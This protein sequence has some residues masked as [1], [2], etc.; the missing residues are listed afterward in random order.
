MNNIFSFETDMPACIAAKNSTAV[1]SNEH[2]RDGKASLK[3]CFAPGADI[4]FTTPVPFSPLNMESASKAIDTFIFWLCSENPVSGSLKIEFFKDNQACCWFETALG[5]TG[6]RTGWV[7]YERDMQGT[8]QN[9]MDGFR[10]IANTKNEGVLYLDQIIPVVKIDSRH[11]TPDMQFP[12]VHESVSKEANNHWLSL[13]KFMRQQNAAVS[14]GTQAA[15][16][17]ELDIIRLRLTQ[18]ILRYTNQPDE[19]SLKAVIK[20][21]YSADGKMRRIDVM[22]IKESYPVQQREQL[23]ALTD[24]VE[25]REV[26]KAMLD[27]AYLWHKGESGK[28]AQHEAEFIRLFNHLQYLGFAGGSALGTTHHLGYQTRE[29]MY[30]LMLMRRPMADNGLLQAAADTA[31]WYSGSGRALGSD[32]DI[33]LESLD[34]FNTLSHGMLIGALLQE[35]PSAA[36]IMLKGFQKWLNSCLLPAPGLEGT[37][38]TDNCMFHHCNHYPAYA[39]GGIESISA[40]IYFISVPSYKISQQA[41]ESVKK[42]VLAFRVYCNTLEW[43]IGMSSRHPDGTGTQYSGISSLKAFEYLARAGSPDGTQPVDL[44]LAAACMRL[45][46]YLNKEEKPF[47]IAAEQTPT[48]HWGFNYACASV[49]RRGEWMLTVRG[50]SKYIWG[51]E[52]YLAANLYGRYIAYGQLELLNR[53]NPINHRQSGYS[54]FGFNWNF[55]PGTTAIELPFNLL[56][57][58]V[59]N[60]DTYSGFEEMIISDQAFCGGTSLFS[61]GVFAIKLHEHGKYNGTHR[62]NKSYFFIDGYVVCLGS[63][64]ENISDYPTYT[65]IYQKTFDEGEFVCLDNAVVKNT[66]FSD[67]SV[68]TTDQII[69]DSKQ[70][71]YFVAKGQTVK[72]EVLCQTTP[73]HENDEPCTGTFAKALICHGKSPKNAQ[74][75]YALLADDAI[76]AKQFAENVPYTVMQKN[77]QLHQLK[78]GAFIYYVFFEQGGAQGGNIINADTPCLAIES[79]TQNGLSIALCDTDMRFYE[80]VEEDQLNSDGTQ[81]EVS[82]YSRKWQAS[83]SA[84]HEMCLTVKG[85]WQ[86]DNSSSDKTEIIHSGTNT[87]IKQI[88]EEAKTY[89]YSFVK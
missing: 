87:I 72:T 28:K 25:F 55:F 27:L 80:G 64:I 41:H 89:T 19:N 85:I 76:N 61:N 1:I 77:K 38:K 22:H 62:A 63:N 11:H 83:Q 42:A 23:E 86:L 37:F 56:R 88:C 51:N 71:R 84:P 43:S 74:Y 47:D 30:A 7:A 57:S 29:F 17:A 46:S 26:G 32:K 9:D 33:R 21:F 15:D 8:P 75:E 59:R 31:A 5:F 3:W 34:T 39:I 16:E 12:F 6:W 18:Y 78:A 2:S 67:E 49:H 60:V 44:Q 65:T 45:Y 81:R 79:T 10:I 53:G 50:F 35:S 58:N 66:E 54:Q 52:T 69:T 20:G 82:L 4:T 13:L 36:H 24:A 70:N 68:Y 14:A 40:F 48:G 73:N